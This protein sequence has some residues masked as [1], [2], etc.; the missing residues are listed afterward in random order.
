[1]EMRQNKAWPGGQSCATLVPPARSMQALGQAK[2]MELDTK[3]PGQLMEEGGQ[4]LGSDAWVLS[5]GV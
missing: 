3:A 4:G 2:P 5:W 1:M